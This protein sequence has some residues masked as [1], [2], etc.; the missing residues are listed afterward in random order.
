MNQ[1]KTFLELPDF[2]VSGG[3]ISVSYNDATKE[4]DVQISI[5]GCPTKYI[6]AADP[7]L[8]RGPDSTGRLLT[9][10]FYQAMT[11]ASHL[12]FSYRSNP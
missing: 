2:L 8:F 5:P 9:K 6:G 10:C 11:M 4:I 7:S 12:N 1:I 3:E